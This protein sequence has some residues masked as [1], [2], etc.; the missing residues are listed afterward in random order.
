MTYNPQPMIY[1]DV[2]THLTHNKFASDLEETVR[3][4]RQAGLA[5][6]V[7]HGLF[8]H[9]NQIGLLSLYDHLEDTS[10]VPRIKRCV[11]LD[12]HRPIGAH[13]QPATELFLIVGSADA[14][15][16]NLGIATR[17]A[18]SNS[19]FQRD[20]IERIDYKGQLVIVNPTSILA[21][22]NPLIGV[23]NAFGGNQYFHDNLDLLFGLSTCF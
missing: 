7:L 19:F 9:Q 12:Q 8:A 14:D 17:L 4:A 20:R 13:R 16:E 23:G 3:R 22:R 10:D 6:I 18:K 5:A 21:Q 11:T 15:D 2:H 1:A